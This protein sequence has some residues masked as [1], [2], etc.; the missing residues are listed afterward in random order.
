MIFISLDTAYGY[1]FSPSYTFQWRN[2]ASRQKSSR[3]A[4]TVNSRLDKSAQTEGEWVGSYQFRA[5]LKFDRVV[6]QNC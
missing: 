2:R 1:L 6:S 3:A 4:D 5:T